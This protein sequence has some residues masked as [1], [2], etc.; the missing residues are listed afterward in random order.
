MSTD[1]LQNARSTAEQTRSTCSTVRGEAE[2]ERFGLEVV[3]PVSSES[4]GEVSSVDTFGYSLRRKGWDR[5][6]L[7]Q[8]RLEGSFMTHCAIK[9]QHS[10]EKSVELNLGLGWST[11]SVTNP[12]GPF[13]E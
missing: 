5:S 6:F 9:S 4:W 13:S 10:G 12:N 2:D 1:P 3:S 7:V 8:A 11:I